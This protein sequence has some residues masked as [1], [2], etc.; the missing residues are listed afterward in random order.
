MSDWMEVRVEAQ[1]RGGL[2]FVQHGIGPTA[3]QA[4]DSVRVKSGYKV[5]SVEVIRDDVVPEDY[6]MFWTDD[7]FKEERKKRRAKA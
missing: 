7:R 1:H 5:T 3:A 2:K 4:R 6:E